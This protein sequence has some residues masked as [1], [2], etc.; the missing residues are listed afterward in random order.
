MKKLLNCLA[1]TT[2]VLLVSGCAGSSPSVDTN[3]GVSNV[4][5]P[6]NCSTAEADIRVLEE[7]KKTDV[8]EKKS[9]GILGYTPIGLVASGLTSSSDSTSNDE[10]NKMLDDKIALIKTTCGLK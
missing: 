10:Y 3:K 6:V 4:E 9:R 5:K 8:E 1:V 2:A 7:S